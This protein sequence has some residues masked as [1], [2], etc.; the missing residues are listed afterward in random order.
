MN[1]VWKNTVMGIVWSLVLMMVASFLMVFTTLGSIF[2]AIFGSAGAFGSFAFFTVLFLL[3]MLGGFVWFFVNLSK[4][5]TLQRDERDRASVSN[6]RTAYI[7]FIVG[8]LV[9]FIPVVG[10]IAGIICQLVA[11]IMLIMAFGSFSTSVVMNDN[12]RSG[13]SLLKVYAILSLICSILMIIPIVN[14]LAL[15]GLIVGVVLLFI[16]WTRI[17]GGINPELEY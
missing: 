9:T 3:L 4:F 8:A 13:A 16:G 15:I 1:I 10:W 6:I 7:I 12:G 11:Y 5:I 14:I 2:G 17:A